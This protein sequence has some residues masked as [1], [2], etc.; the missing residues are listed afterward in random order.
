[1]SPRSNCILA[2]ATRS[3]EHWQSSV[4]NTATAKYI[5]SNHELLRL[6]GRCSL[7]RPFALWWTVRSARPRSACAIASPP[8]PRVAGH[9][10]DQRRGSQEKSPAA[11][12]SGA[13][14]GRCAARGPMLT[15]GFDDSRQW[16]TK[17]EA[18]QAGRT[19]KS[20]ADFRQQVSE[21]SP[22]IGAS[23]LRCVAPIRQAPCCRFRTG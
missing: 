20:P 12:A 11:F 14:G 6:V 8:V 10:S 17:G 22:T 5:A 16:L 2:S 23:R 19:E 1:M 13:I 7:D 4:T 18:A 3:A 9:F 15:S 21:R